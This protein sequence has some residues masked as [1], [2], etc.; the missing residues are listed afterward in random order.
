MEYAIWVKRNVGSRYFHIDDIVRV[1]DHYGEAQAIV[2][3][4]DR[5]EIVWID[6]S[7]VEKI[8]RYK[9]EI[10]KLCSVGYARKVRKHAGL[11]W[12]YSS[13]FDGAPIREPCYD[14]V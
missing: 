6:A 9:P 12:Q 7:E 5:E 3:N 1:F 4:D 10:V 8:L 14:Y 2:D 11:R 13:R